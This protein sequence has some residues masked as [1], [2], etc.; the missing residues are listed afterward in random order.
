[1]VITA[2]QWGCSTVAEQGIA[3]QGWSRRSKNG[4]TKEHLTA[5]AMA[6]DTDLLLV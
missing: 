3:G 6:V 1:M 5:E 2:L 4:F